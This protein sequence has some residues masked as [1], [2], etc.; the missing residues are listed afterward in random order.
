MLIRQNFAMAIAYNVVSVPFAIAGLV[1][2][3]A[4]ALA[5]SLSSIVVV[6]NALRL[7][8]R[9]KKGPRTFGATKPATVKI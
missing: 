7:G 3:L 8:A 5:M 9:V 4:A 6:G 2:P 1:T